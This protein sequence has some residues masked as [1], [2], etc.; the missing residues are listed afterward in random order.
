MAAKIEELEVIASLPEENRQEIRK[1][2]G[3]AVNS[4]IRIDAEKDH[5]KT[6]SDDLK[7]MFDIS[8]ST[9]NELIK[10]FYEEQYAEQQAERGEKL[11]TA[12][13]ALQ[14]E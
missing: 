7:D 12:T 9:I 5:I 13:E 1:K 3:E 8:T 11:Q 10:A 6:I 2:I 4:K 14:G